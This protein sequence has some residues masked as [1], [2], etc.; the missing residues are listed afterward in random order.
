[1]SAGGHYGG[2]NRVC[3]IEAGIAG[4]ATAKVLYEDGFA[5]TVFE[6]EPAIGGVWSALR[7][8]PDLRANNPRETYAFSDHPYS[9]TA[10]DRNLFAK[11]L[12]PFWPERYAG[13]KIER[14]AREKLAHPTNTVSV[15]R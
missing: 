14:R 6:K 13:L 10:D 8:Y 3:V 4:L 9:K 1:M 15:N 5:V 11:N 12:S 7:T 2:A